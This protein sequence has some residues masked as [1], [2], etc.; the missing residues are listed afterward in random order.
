M[1][2]LMSLTRRNHYNPCFWTALWNPSY[3]QD[4]I[5]ER[6]KPGSHRC[7]EVATLNLPANRILKTTVEHVHVE[8]ALGIAEMTPE[9]MMNFCRRRFPNKYDEFS[10]RLE[11]YQEVLYMDFENILE[12]M[13]ATPAYRVLR[14]LAAGK[15]LVRPVDKVVLS[16]FVV[17]HAL[18]SHEVMTSMIAEFAGLGM[19][20][21]EYFWVLKNALGTNLLDVPATMLSFSHW[22]FYRADRHLLPL[23]DSPIMIGPRALMVPIS[24]RLLLEIDLTVRTSPDQW[25]VKDKIPSNKQREFRRRSIANS[26]RQIV[27]HDEGV[28][29]D[30][31]ATREFQHRVESIRAT[32]SYRRGIEEAAGRVRWA[33]DGFPGPHIHQAIGRNA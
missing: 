31:Q 30:W 21:F 23:C 6:A 14:D 33:V 17:I 22:T 2:S 29:A 12:G 18:R 13:E 7:Q 27:F 9:A 8:K 1:L 11:N 19:Q 15:P 3:Y 28:L 10:R 4:V 24:P 32:E 5:E 26:Y 16:C 20:K 25:T